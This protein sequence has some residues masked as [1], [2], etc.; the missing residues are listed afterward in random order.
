MDVSWNLN[1]HQLKHSSLHSIYV[2]LCLQCI[3]AEKVPEE[4]SRRP[5]KTRNYGEVSSGHEIRK[6]HNCR[7]LVFPIKTSLCKFFL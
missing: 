2:V 5:E 7:P 4:K 1:V 3:Q 6:H